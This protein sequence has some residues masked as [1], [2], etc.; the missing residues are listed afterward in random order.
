MRR[1]RWSVL[2][3]LW[4]DEA[5]LVVLILIARGADNSVKRSDIV[6]CDDYLRRQFKVEIGDILDVVNLVDGLLTILALNI[7]RITTLQI[8]ISSCN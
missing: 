1:V 6:V 7:K 4:D 3:S 8:I 2:G 5:V